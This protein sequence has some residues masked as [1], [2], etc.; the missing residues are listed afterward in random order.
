M[1]DGACDVFCTHND[2]PYNW[3]IEGGQEQTGSAADS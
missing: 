2:I 3:I 1:H